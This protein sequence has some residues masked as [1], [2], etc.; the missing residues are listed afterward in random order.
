MIDTINILKNEIKKYLAFLQFEKNLSINTVNSYWHDL[1]SYITYLNQNYKIKS[2]NSIKNRHIRNYIRDLTKYLSPNTLKSSTINR[3]ISSIRGFHKYLIINKIC[4]NNASKNILSIKISKKI[5]D[6]LSVEE[7]DLLIDNIKD[8]NHISI[9]DKSIITLLYSSGLR[10][11]ELLSLNLT[12][13][14]LKEELIRVFGKGNKERIVPFGKIAKTFLIKYINN[15]RPIYAKRA[16][17]KGIIFLSNRGKSISRKT[18]WNLVKKYSLISTLNKNISPH[19]FRHSFAS[20]LLE[21]GADLR[22][23]QELLGHSNI[24]TTQIYTHI[25]KTY[26]KEIHKEFHPRG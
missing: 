9:R 7:I 5:P 2:F 14:L 25:D 17:S 21:G 1:N 10:V 13:L 23:V 26:L 4:K 20:H 6:I 19:T 18:L 3:S 8:K 11:S 16:P 22:T 12:N 15:V 24:S